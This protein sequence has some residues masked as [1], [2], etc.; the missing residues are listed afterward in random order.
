MYV[1]FG[2]SS[3]LPTACQRT[4]GRSNNAEPTAK[5]RAGSVNVATATAPAPWTVKPIRRRRVTVSPSNAPGMRRSDVY[6]DFGG[7]RRG[8][9]T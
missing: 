1:S 7:S 9:G 6:L 4:G 8:A 2:K 5:P 3:G